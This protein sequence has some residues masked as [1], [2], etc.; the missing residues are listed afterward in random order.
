MPWIILPQYSYVRIYA[1]DRN[2]WKPILCQH[3]VH[4]WISEYMVHSFNHMKMYISF[5]NSYRIYDRLQPNSTLCCGK[6]R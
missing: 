2:A 3:P 5:M 6:L 4:N 1:D